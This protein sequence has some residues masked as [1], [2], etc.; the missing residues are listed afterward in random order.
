MSV[1]IHSVWASTI[2]FHVYEL[3][4][5]CNPLRSIP[6]VTYLYA[7]VGLKWELVISFVHCLCADEKIIVHQFGNSNK[8][9]E[10]AAFP[11]FSV[12]PYL[13]F[14]QFFVARCTFAIFVWL[15]WKSTCNRNITFQNLASFSLK[16]N[17]AETTCNT[18]ST[19][20]IN[21]IDFTTVCVRAC[22]CVF[23]SLFISS[24]EFY[25][26]RLKVFRLPCCFFCF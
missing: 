8:M 19:H 21:M 14:S 22:V 26:L 5:T 9:N 12:S 11:S 23:L 10:L 24:D 13:F 17:V 15:Y 20:R 2:L 16:K 25:R 3:A 1:C 6:P 4:F 7:F 18:Q